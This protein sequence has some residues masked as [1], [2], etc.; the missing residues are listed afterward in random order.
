MHTTKAYEI[1]NSFIY[2]SSQQLSHFNQS[3]IILF[4]KEKTI[5]NKY[6]E[7]KLNKTNKTLR[8]NLAY[9]LL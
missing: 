2:Y 8:N 4:S 1:R 5:T 6:N 7:I 3:F 9:Y